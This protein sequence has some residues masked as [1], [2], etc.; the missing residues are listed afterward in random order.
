MRVSWSARRGAARRSRLTSFPRNGTTGENKS[1]AAGET[2]LFLCLERFLPGASIRGLS[3]PFLSFSSQVCSRHLSASLP[4]LST[5]WGAVA[6][7]HLEVSNVQVCHSRCCQRG[8]MMEG[9]LSGPV[10][11]SRR[12][13][14]RLSKCSYKAQEEFFFFFLNGE[15]SVVER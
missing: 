11:S 4:S 10:L 15:R 6:T 9:I 7:S 12:D 8:A 5:D 13:Q 2:F 1:R 14:G 3:P